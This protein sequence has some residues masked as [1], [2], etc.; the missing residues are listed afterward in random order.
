MEKESNHDVQLQVGVKVLLKDKDDKFFLLHRSEKKYPNVVGRW[1][2]PGGRIEP[3]TSLLKN[4][5]REIMEE[6][7]LDLSG[8]P[9]LLAAQDILRVPG[10]HIVRLTYI[11]KATGTV[12]L[13]TDENDDYKWLTLN[14][15]K[16]VD[17]LDQYL[18]EL[19]DK[20]VLN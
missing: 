18:K 20:N 2:I 8:E 3:G 16:M 19:V 6:T 7:S 13:D 4:L 14:E 9:K 11:G 15:L 12:K 1:D 17:E 10:K 5:K